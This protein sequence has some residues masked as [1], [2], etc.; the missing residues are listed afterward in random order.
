MH[1]RSGKRGLM[2]HPGRLPWVDTATTM[3]DWKVAIRV[4]EASNPDS[5]L[6]G[7]V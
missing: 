5:R 4:G 3:H 7:S 6:Y 2:P 1:A